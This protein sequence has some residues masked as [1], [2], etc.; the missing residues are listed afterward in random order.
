MPFIVAGVGILLFLGL[1]SFFYY[2][3]GPAYGP[4]LAQ[5]AA[6]RRSVQANAKLLSQAVR[7]LDQGLLDPLYRQSADWTSKAAR[8]VADYN[9]EGD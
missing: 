4:S 5:Q 2:L 8:I 3:T 6:E 1:G 7:L 9:E